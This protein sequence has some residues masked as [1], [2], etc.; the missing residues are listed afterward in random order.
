MRSR[1]TRIR[2]RTAADTAFPEWEEMLE[3]PV[4]SPEDVITVCLVDECL[5]DMLTPPA[6]AAAA[7]AR[8]HAPRR[9]RQPPSRTTF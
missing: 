6:V 9:K 2:T 1:R 5:E 7:R 4:M 3:I 8:A